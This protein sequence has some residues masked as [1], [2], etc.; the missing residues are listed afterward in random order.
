MQKSYKITELVLEHIEENQNTCGGKK[1]ACKII[2]LFLKHIDDKRSFYSRK[3]NKGMISLHYA[4]LC[5]NTEVLKT[6]LHFAKFHGIETNINAIDSKG[7]T[8]LHVAVTNNREKVVKYLLDHA[9]EEGINVEAIDFKG[10]TPFQCARL[11]DRKDIVN[12][13]LNFFIIRMIP[14]FI[15][16]PILSYFSK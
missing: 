13:F 11:A 8:P 3:D 10:Q 1:K 14:G 2:E 4:C 6:L 7:E 15:R 5:S 9:G 16:N 12:E